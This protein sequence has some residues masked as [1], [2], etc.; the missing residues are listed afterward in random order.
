MGLK[1]HVVK[2]VLLAIAIVILLCAPMSVV[3]A[4]GIYQPSSQG[5]A[6]VPLTAE[7][8]I[9][10]SGISGFSRFL[11]NFSAG[12]NYHSLSFRDGVRFDEL[13][14][15]YSVP[16]RIGNGVVNGFA[17]A[18][19]TDL[20]DRTLT[21]GLADAALRFGGNWLTKMG[22]RA[23]FGLRGEYDATRRGNQWYSG[24]QA[25]VEMFQFIDRDIASLRVTYY[26]ESA[27]D[28]LY[29]TNKPSKGW[30]VVAWYS[31]AVNAVGARLMLIVDGYELDNGLPDYQRGWNL[32]ASVSDRTGL[33]FLSGGLGYDSFV[34]SNYTVGASIN[35]SL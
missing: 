6:L 30:E 25:A 4:Q 29:L 1:V 21:L 16:L 33:F 31:H 3:E 5:S 20:K 11:G 18:H 23:Y 27:G 10:G 14:L 28:Q 34:L 24:G 8:G 19:I 7:N 22:G 32:K 15:R 13:R 17:I 26:A 2:R 12:Y 9:A 35:L